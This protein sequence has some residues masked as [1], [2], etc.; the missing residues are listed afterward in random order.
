M[1]RDS[2]KLALSVEVRS[3]PKSMR[4]SLSRFGNNYQT[5]ATTTALSLVLLSLPS[6]NT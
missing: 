4:P 1:F 3:K 5:F 2:N 6:F